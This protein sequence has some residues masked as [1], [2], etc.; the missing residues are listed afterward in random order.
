[1]VFRAVPVLAMMCLI[2]SKCWA[3]YDNV[4]KMSVVFFF[5]QV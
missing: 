1:M 2:L 4:V 3:D 5:N